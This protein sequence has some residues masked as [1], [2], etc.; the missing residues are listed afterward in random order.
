MTAVIAA[1]VPKPLLR[2][3][4]FRPVFFLLA[5]V[6]GV[7]VVLPLSWLLYY[8]LIDKSGAFTLGNFAALIT[9]ATMRRPFLLAIG[10]AFGVG[11]LS[12]A[13]ATPLAWLVSR[14]D[15]PGR[16]IVR[17]LVTAS[18]VTP[19]FLGAIAWEI[20]AAPNSGLIN[21]LHR[22]L[23]GSEAYEH[24]VDIY[25]IEGLVFAIACYTFPYVFTLV[26]NGLDRVPSDLEDASAILGGRTATTLRRVTIPLVMPA[27]LAGSL[28]AILQALTMFG[29]PAILA[30]PAGF[31]VITTKIW[32]LF[33]YPPRPGLAAAAALPLLLI[34][35]LLLQ[36]KSW[37]LGR[38]GYTVLGGKSGEPRIAR[39]GRWKWAAVAFVA[40]VLLLTVIL[41]Y[42]AL[43]KTALTRNVSEPLTWSTLTLHNF[44]F[45]FFDFSAT[46]MALWN[47]LLLGFST[48]TIGTA[49]AL[50]AAY[51]VSRR[52]VRGSAL[53]GMLATAPVAIPGIV[54]GVGVFLTYSHPQ[55][56]LYGTLWILLI[57]FLTIEMPAG[58][59]QMSSAFHGIHPE[60]EEASRILGASRL[61]TLRLITAPLLRTSVIATWCFVFIGTIRELSATILLTTANTKLV[62]V[63]IYDLN[64]SGDL[65]AIS[66]LGLMLLAVSFAVVFLANRLPVLGGQRLPHA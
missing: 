2:V 16:R 34:T 50:M 29:S 6:L 41:P 64:E 46:R 39:L 10:M 32:S 63:I 17:A 57:A 3:D 61:N 65:G 18:F 13:I 36:G 8:S 30:L 48:A 66:V 26:A 11:V 44:H 43:L 62:S 52:T 25:T 58:Y 49:I 51:M 7:L 45:V 24:L 5:A 37:I 1:P 53:L 55:L 33:Q 56:M 47:T 59:Q 15:L 27:M 4:L 60:L 14:T 35:V 28:I 42:A 9:D 19:P 54:L 21:Q 22:Y 20:L 38:K 12:C 31:H 40:I 23:T